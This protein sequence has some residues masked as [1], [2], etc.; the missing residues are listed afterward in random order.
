MAKSQSFSFD[1]GVFSYWGT[2][3]LAFLLSVCTLGFLYP[4]G[5]ILRLRW[6]SKHTA[7]NGVPLVFNG[8]AFGLIARWLQWWLLSVVTVGIY[9]FWVAPRLNK[10]I[11]ENT[12]FDR[13]A[14]PPSS[15]II[16]GVTYVP[17][18]TAV[19]T[20]IEHNASSMQVPEIDAVANEAMV[21]IGE[22]PLE[23]GEL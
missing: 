1:G 19:S 5:L 7:V 4:F 8:S 15:F 9:S 12:D 13:S 10:W 18:N 3:L 14:I 11:V 17:L 20:A 21:P 6:R 2:Q 22:V 23:N 16:N